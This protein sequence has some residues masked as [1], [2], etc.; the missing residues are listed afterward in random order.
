MLN[1]HS[2][3][4]YAV[5]SMIGLVNWVCEESI[6]NGLSKHGM[7]RPIHFRIQSCIIEQWSI[8]KGVRS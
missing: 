6:S 1:L 8:K 3:Y 4:D 7:P 2:A 5:N